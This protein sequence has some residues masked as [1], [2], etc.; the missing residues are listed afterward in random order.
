MTPE[1]FVKVSKLCLDLRHEDRFNRSRLIVGIVGANLRID[2]FQTAVEVLCPCGVQVEGRN[3]EWL[4]QKGLCAFL[5]MAR[6]SFESPL[7][8]ELNYCGGSEDDRPVV[9]VGMLRTWL[10]NKHDL[11]KCPWMMGF[12]SIRAG[13]IWIPD[14][15]PDK[16]LAGKNLEK[17]EIPD[18]WK[19][20]KAGLIWIPDKFP[21]KFLTALLVSGKG[22]TFDSGGLCLKSCD[23]MAEFR[24]DMAG[25]AVIVGVMKALAT[26]GIPLNVTGTILKFH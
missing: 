6:G 14:K 5:S 4:H 21:D 23:E 22:V 8:L 10:P 17:L 20:G 15:F 1:Q 18:N 12:E 13:V 25:G 3:S 24:A 16:S 26:L 11:L 19:P 9:L 7:L 2:I